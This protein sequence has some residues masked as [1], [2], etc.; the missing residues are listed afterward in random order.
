MQSISKFKKGFIFLLCVISIFSKYAWLVPLKDKK[1]ISIVADF[2]KILD[3]SNRKP[4]KIQVDKGSEFYYNSFKKWLKDNDI[5]MYSIHN[6]GKYVVDERFIRTLK[7]N[8]YDFG[9]K[10][11]VY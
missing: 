5:E 2:Q 7:T 3:D 9:V 6:E 10:K 8:I 1:S 4:N 11:C